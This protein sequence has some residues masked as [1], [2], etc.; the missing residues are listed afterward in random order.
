MFAAIFIIMFFLILAFFLAYSVLGVVVGFCGFLLMYFV[1]SYIGKKL[2]GNERV[3]DDSFAWQVRFY[4]SLFFSGIILA[5]TPLWDE[6]GFC[7]NQKSANVV[8]QDQTLRDRLLDKTRTRTFYQSDERSCLRYGAW[9]YIGGWSTDNVRGGLL[10]VFLFLFFGPIILSLLIFCYLMIGSIFETNMPNSAENGGGA[11]DKKPPTVIAGIGKVGRVIVQP[12][13]GIYWD[14]DVTY[15]GIE[16]LDRPQEHVE[17]L[18]KNVEDIIERK[19]LTKGDYKLWFIRAAETYLED[20]KKYE[21]LCSPK[22]LI[23][24]LQWAQRH[25]PSL[26]RTPKS[27]HVGEKHHGDLSLLIKRLKEL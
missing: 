2:E 5:S 1:I 20:A 16:G 19:H 27:A 12:D 8:Y 6:D 15:T 11:L 26:W 21:K 25:I 22:T 24:H 4:M 14:G 3:F 10:F 23:E 18:L 9:N 7:A 17:K 13:T